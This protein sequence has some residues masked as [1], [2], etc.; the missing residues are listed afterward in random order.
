[1]PRPKIPRFVAAYPVLSTF[2]PQGVAPTGE[3]FLS[4]EGL[5]AIRLSDFECLDQETAATLMDISR[6][7]YGRILAEARGTV[8]QAL[9]T[10]KALRI[11]GGTYAFRG[12]QRR[13]RRRGGRGNY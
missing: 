10:G 13:R 1:M 5:E 9:V 2:I 11:E 7:T 3:V 8:A 6:Q 4:L 12:Q